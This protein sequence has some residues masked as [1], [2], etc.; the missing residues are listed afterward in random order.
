M[1][2][3]VTTAE[4]LDDSPIH[5]LQQPFLSYLSEDP[6]KILYETKIQTHILCQFAPENRK[7]PPKER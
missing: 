6:T 2:M 7:K 5:P 1:V 4:P 3:E